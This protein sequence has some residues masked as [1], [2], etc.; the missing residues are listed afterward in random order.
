MAIT[1]TGEIVTEDGCAVWYR[2]SCWDADTL[3]PSR[4]ESNPAAS[5]GAVQ[6]PCLVLAKHD[7]APVGR[8]VHL[9][10]GFTDAGLRFVAVV[11]A[12]DVEADDLAGAYASP[13]LTSWSSD[14]LIAHR[15][16]LDGLALVAAT[17][18][19]GCRPL[20]V[21]NA[22]LRDWEPGRRPWCDAPAIIDRAARAMQV[23]QRSASDP[24]VVHRPP[25]DTA[26]LGPIEHAAAHGAVLSVR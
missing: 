20:T 8:V 10:S 19:I 17:A 26:P 15:S 2:R 21:I 23:E 9:E 7:G 18:G 5:F 16:R 12:D 14:G 6:P 22:D 13:E 3:R 4:I 25:S 1:L 24:L 11:D